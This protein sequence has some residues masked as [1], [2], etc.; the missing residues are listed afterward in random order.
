MGILVLVR[1]MPRMTLLGAVWL[2]AAAVLFALVFLSTSS[3]AQSSRSGTCVRDLGTLGASRGV[4]TASGAITRDAGCV[5]LQRRPGSD[6]VYYAQ[7][8]T[9]TLEEGYALTFNRSN[10]N[11]SRTR[12]LLIEGHSRDGS[13]RVVARDGLTHELVE[14]GIYTVEVTF[15]GPDQI[16][17]YSFWMRRELVRREVAATAA[18][19]S[20]GDRAAVFTLTAVAP[21]DAGPVVH[22]AAVSLSWSTVAGT[23]AAGTDFV[24]SSGTARIPVD[25]SRA[26]ITV[27]LVDDSISESAESFSVRL[28]SASGATLAGAAA[29]ATI[30][31]DDPAPLVTAPTASTCDEARVSGEVGDVF[32][33]DQTGH[34]QRT[35]VFVGVDLS[36]E[37]G[38]GGSDGYRTG[39]EILTGPAAPLSSGWCVQGGESPVTVTAATGCAAATDDA[40]LLSER[41]QATHIVRIPDTAVG[42]AHQLRAWIDLNKNGVRDAGEESQIFATDFTSQAADS[43][44]GTRFAPAQDFEITRLVD[45]NLV[46]RAGHWAVLR[47]LAEIPSGEFTYDP[48]LSSVVPVRVPLANTDMGAHVY[49]GPAALL[50]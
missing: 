50:R 7:R 37:G 40:G 25:G 29:T 24:A 9:F 49:A 5:S 32:D 11:A 34:S 8:W 47:L 22:V 1:R 42:E 16:G 31:D 39:V 14:G 48:Q 36:C 27:P 35:D 19:V 28:T 33:I 46:G 26:T 21:P 18:E 15:R 3:G 6:D 41:T 38:S 45:G 12:L 20:E 13:G 10:P 4:L 30:T 2:V 44:S 23:A 43:G 17:E